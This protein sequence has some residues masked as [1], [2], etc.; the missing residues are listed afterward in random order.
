MKM[1]KKLFIPL[2]AAL[3]TIGLTS[4][5]FAAWVIMGETMVK[6]DDAQFVAYTV[7]DQSI[8]FTATF[9]TGEQVVFGKTDGVTEN[10]L[11]AEGIATQDLT[12]NLTI[13]LT[14]WSSVKHLDIT[15]EIS[16]VTSS[17]AIPSEYIAT[18]GAKTV[19]ITPNS[20]TNP[21]SWTVKIGDETVSS[22]NGS[23]ANPTIMVPL[24]FAWEFGEGE[25]P[26][27]YYN[28]LPNTAENKSAA[29]TALQAIAA[30][31]TVNFTV[32]VTGRTAT[33]K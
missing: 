4:V 30:L 11:K 13:T 15:F 5:G 20:A 19:T 25:N 16:D 26:Y 22:F 14:N 7:E 18:P 23:Q 1:K 10:W 29:V 27:S 21:T 33:H 24:T 2:I 32:E 3:L 9:G 12:A 17:V 31:D 8:S 28:G 6:S